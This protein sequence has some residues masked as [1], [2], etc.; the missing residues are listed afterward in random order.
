MPVKVATPVPPFATGRVPVRSA[1]G[2]V[3]SAVIAVVPVPFT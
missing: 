1:T 3:A 2:T